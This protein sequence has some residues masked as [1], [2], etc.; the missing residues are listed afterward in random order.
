MLRKLL[1]VPVLASAIIL[2]LSSCTDTVYVL[3]DV[4]VPPRPVFPTLAGGGLS[5][6][7]DNTYEKLVR[8][9][10]MK[11]AHIELLEDVIRSA[12]SS[13]EVP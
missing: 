13:D 2:N 12:S 10:A 8:R 9:D 7:S 11:T 5:C 1:I 3:P 4:E 6:L